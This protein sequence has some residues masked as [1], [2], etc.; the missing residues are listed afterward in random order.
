MTELTHDILVVDDEEDIRLLIT[1]LLDDEGYTTREAEHSQSALLEI[2]QRRPSLVIL[3]IWLQGSE[4][5]GLQFLDLLQ[6]NYSEIPVIMISGHGNV[7]TAVSA[8]K[9]GAYD[10]IEKPFKSDRLLHMAERAIE[11]AR[12]KRENL[13]LRQRTGADVEMV[14]SSPAI[15]Q[16]RAGISK[17]APTGSRVLITGPAGVGKEIAARLIHAES[18]RGNG[19]FIAVNCASMHPDRLEVELFGTET[20]GDDSNAARHTGVFEAAHN[21]TLFL[22]EV[23]DM[24]LETQGKIVRVLQE[25]MFERVGGST[26]IQVDV[27]V[28][29]ASSRD[30]EQEIAS[31]RFREDLYYRLAV[32]PIEIPSLDQRREDIAELVEHFI[33]RWAQASGLAERM[34]GD[35]VLA[36]LR[37]HEWPGNV[38]QLRNVVE[39][40]LIM[41]PRD[42]QGVIHAD[43]LPPEISGSAAALRGDTGSRIMTLDLRAARETFE[44][45]YLMAQINRFGGNISKTAEFIGMERSAL[46]RKLKSLGLG[47]DSA[48]RAKTGS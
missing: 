18:N 34:V 48:E 5:D 27:R 12:L 14:G 38:R 20:S 45:E 8:I 31:G 4:L 1:G 36:A 21:G 47:S 28:I 25:Q 33:S 40:L 24:P 32:V 15:R 7:E 46:H 35:D 37:A 3:D 43:A 11:A 2:N 13:D 16:V 22:D 42:E 6:E 29:A 39:R 23:G 44:R 26:I 17:V 9:S 41:S 19:P 10:Y 30:L